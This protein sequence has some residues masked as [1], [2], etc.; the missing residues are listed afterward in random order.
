MCNFL[1]TGPTLFHV[2]TLFSSQE[3]CVRRPFLLHLCRHLPLSASEPGLPGGWGVA[4]P[5]AFHLHPPNDRRH[6]VL[7]CLLAA[8]TSSLQKCVSQS[9]AQYFKTRALILERGGGREKWGKHQCVVASCVPPTG[10]L[11]ATQTCALTGNRTDDPL[12][13]RLALNP[14]SHTSRGRAQFLIGTFVILLLNCKSSLYNLNTNLLSD[15]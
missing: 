1:R 14:L 12:V 15:I 11:A 7:R 6:C 9:F 4:P 3:Q 2:A 8:C 5:C 13:H 10:D